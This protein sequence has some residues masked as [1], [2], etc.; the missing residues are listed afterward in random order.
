MKVPNLEELRAS[1]SLDRG[2]GGAS[3]SPFSGSHYI[4]HATL[5]SWWERILAILGLVFACITL[6]NIIIRN[7]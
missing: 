3:F 2:Q 7:L 6:G 4:R 5:G 1:G